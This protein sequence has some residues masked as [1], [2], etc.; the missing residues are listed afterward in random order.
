MNHALVSETFKDGIW[1]STFQHQESIQAL[2]KGLTQDDFLTLLRLASSALLHLHTS[3][4]SLKYKEAL[5]LEID[6][7]TQRMKDGYK[8]EREAENSQ[9]TMEV[10]RLKTVIEELQIQN[11]SLKTQFNDLNTVNQETFRTSLASMKAEKDEQ[12]TKEIER[13][14]EDMKERVG[15]LQRIYSEAAIK[16]KKEACVSSEIGKKGEKDFEELVAEYT[17][18]GALTNTSKIPHNADWSCMIRKT[19]TL[20]EI[21]NYSSDVPTREIT[22]FEDDMKLHSDIHFGAFLSMN[23][24]ISGKRFDKT[25]VLDWT[26]SGQMLVY[27]SYFRAQDMTAMFLFLDMCADIAYRCYRLV[28]DRPDDSDTC[29]KLQQKIQGIQSLVEKELVSLATWMR[30]MKAEHQVAMDILSKQHIVNLGRIAHTKTSL[31]NILDLMGS[32]DDHGDI[33]SAVAPEVVASPVNKKS[34][35][36]ISL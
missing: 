7:H 34:K 30:D 13:M 2:V 8:K 25:I 5:T 20:F 36:V 31:T 28:Q 32:S 12:Y 27:I 11:K 1:S 10:I 3:A 17:S 9:H 6:T 29:L 18:W 35:K 33:V 22:K 4:S 23:T 24:G 15:E 16:A 21:K 19:S 26:S 14:R